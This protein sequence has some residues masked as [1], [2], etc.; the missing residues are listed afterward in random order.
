MKVKEFGI[1]Y[2]VMQQ[3]RRV[4]VQR[5]VQ[6]EMHA[7]VTLW[8]EE[9]KRARQSQHPPMEIVVP[10]MMQIYPRLT[11]QRWQR[12]FLRF[13]PNAK[14]LKLHYNPAPLKK[15]VTRLS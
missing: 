1:I 12:P 14:I 10:I 6:A 5:M 2:S 9:Q 4:S 11:Q 8:K 3:V 15:N 7:Q 13:Y